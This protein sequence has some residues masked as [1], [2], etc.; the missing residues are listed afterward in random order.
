M[1]KALCTKNNKSQG[2]YR[3]IHL[4][5]KFTKYFSRVI[6]I[7]ID[8]FIWNWYGDFSLHRL[9]PGPSEHAR[10]VARLE[11]RNTDDKCVHIICNT[12]C[13]FVIYNILYSSK[14]HSFFILLDTIR[15]LSQTTY[16][17][18]D[19]WLQKEK[20]SH[21]HMYRYPLQRIYIIQCITYYIM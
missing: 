21:I 13:K 4:K 7:H 11:M 15:L 2:M 1:C 10:E 14:V 19:K 8:I 18:V 16:L 5:Y 12:S 17:F 6:T 3:H 20:V 9:L